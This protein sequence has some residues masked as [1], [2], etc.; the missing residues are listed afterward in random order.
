MCEQGMLGVSLP[1]HATEALVVVDLM[2]CVARSWS[3]MLIWQ[4]QFRPNLVSNARPT[5]AQGMLVAAI[6][7]QHF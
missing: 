1:I 4:P 7:A 2:E 3:L 5:A 6:A